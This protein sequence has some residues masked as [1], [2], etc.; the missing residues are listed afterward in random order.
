MDGGPRVIRQPKGNCPFIPA[1]KVV[2][3]LYPRRDTDEQVPRE[4]AYAIAKEGVLLIEG[5]VGARK[6][7]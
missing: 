2:L 6:Y 4:M 7:Y 5:G 3:D 1:W